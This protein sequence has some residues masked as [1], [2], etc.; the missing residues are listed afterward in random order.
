MN[1]RVSSRAG[2]VRGRIERI[3]RWL[4]TPDVDLN[5]KSWLM[6]AGVIAVISALLR[7]PI[8]TLIAVAIAAV[9]LTVRVWWDQCFRGLTYTRKFSTVRA[10][11]GDEISLDLE[12]VNAKP[13]P[14][15]RLEVSDSATINVEVLNRT[16]EPSENHQTRTLRSL[17]SLGMYER[18]NYRY[19]IACRSRGWHRF[20]PVVLSASDPLG[21]VVRRETQKGIEGFLVYPRIVPITQLVVPARQ[22]FGDFTPQQSLVEDPMRMAGVREYVPGD[23]PKRVHWR[24]TA[25]T[26]TM[27]TRIYEPSASPVA[28]IFLDTITFSYLWEGQNSDLLELAVTTAASLANQLLSG[29]HQVG[30]YANAPMP[31]RSRSVRVPPGRRSGQLTRILEDLA[32]LMPAFGERIERMVVE[33]LPRLPWGSTIVIVTCRVTEGMQRSLLRLARSSGTQRFVIIA[34]GATPELVPDLRRRLP[35]YHLSD[36]EAWDEIQHI[37]LTRQS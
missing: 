14:I 26:G 11:H 6:A 15:T 5:T 23:S 30:L 8:L 28:A 1:Q 33:E 17:F 9:A 19:R 22:P 32:M 13:L 16:L 10:F 37:T 34:I 36:E 27:Q 21:L 4:D 7:Q 24:A 12:V 18:V 3:G 2:S 29:R 25:R 31:G 35:V 20:G